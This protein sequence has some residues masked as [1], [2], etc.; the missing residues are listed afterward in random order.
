MQIR[1]IIEITEA[2]G[3]SETK[4]ET[5][6]KGSIVVGR[7][8]KSD[9]IID[10]HLVSL[11][12]ARFEF[13]DGALHVVDLGS[14]EGVTV[15]GKPASNIKLRAKDVV[16][17]G[18]VE[19]LLSTD[20]STWS[21]TERRIVEL[22]ENSE[23]WINRVVKSLDIRNRLPSLL[24]LSLIAALLVL[25]FGGYLPSTGR[26]V[27]LLSSGPISDS[28]GMLNNDCG[29]CHEGVL[30]RVEDRKCLSCHNLSEHSKSL[31]TF[32]A[33]ASHPTANTKC[34]DCH[35]EHKGQTGLMIHDDRLCNSCHADIKQF[36]PASKLPNVTSFSQHPELKVE[37]RQ[38]DELV[39]VSM[40][41]KA[42]L[43]D[44]TPLKLNH[45]LHLKDGIRGPNGKVTLRCQD[46]HRLSTDFKTLEPITFEHDCKSC[47]PLGFDDRLPG[48]QVPHGDP[49]VVYNYIYA[50]YA[51]LFLATEEEIPRPAEL[52]IRRKPGY[53]EK[54]DRDEAIAFTK[55][56][57][58]E[59]ARKSEEQLF[60][61]TACYL[62]HEISEEKRN[63]NERLSKFEIAKVEIPNRWM[64][65]AR[66][67]HGA[68]EELT[69]ESCHSKV[70]DSEKT[71]DLNLPNRDTCASCHVTGHA[72]GK[73]SSECM[74][75]HSYHDS[76]P[77][78]ESKK[79]KLRLK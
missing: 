77:L 68:H 55:D 38:G 25:F 78:A 14:A 74:L 8:G 51:K 46:C 61:K 1:Y 2:N 5:F 50:E 31:T 22:K 63:E 43:V 70:R 45:K 9:I 59:Q 36:A 54:Q 48:D 19:I 44:P 58:I 20:G 12:H 23:E 30:Q 39:R 16:K 24:S 71:K 11:E 13:V 34:G 66:F 60:T 65:A 7:G 57:I 47:H 69:C 75:C 42:K 3:L 73:L 64:K 56:N 27:E 18:P 49:D 41:D 37:I 76:Q 72:A 35:H 26:D 53:D 67:G 28:H 62:C 52:N 33:N 6:D 10:N 40:D 79:R 15:N 17:L 4:V 21:L 32:L 29:A